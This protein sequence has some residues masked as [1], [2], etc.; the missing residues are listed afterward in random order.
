MGSG[1]GDVGR[2]HTTGFHHP[3]RTAYNESWNWNRQLPIGRTVSD[4]RFVSTPS[5]PSTP[6]PN[7]NAGELDDVVSHDTCEKSE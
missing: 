7:G 5:V 6:D 2:N 3:A 1:T 4:R